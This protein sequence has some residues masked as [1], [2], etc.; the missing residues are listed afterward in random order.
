VQAGV[1]HRFNR[2]RYDAER[3]AIDFRR[4]LRNEVDV[5]HLKVALAT[6]AAGVVHPSGASVWLR[7]VPR[8]RG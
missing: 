1:D 8:P 6:T 4:R 7:P 5:D 2:A 3:T